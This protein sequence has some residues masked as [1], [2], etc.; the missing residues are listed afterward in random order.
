MFPECLRCDVKMPKIFYQLS[1]FFSE[2]L[3]NEFSEII[4][5]GIAQVTNI[6]F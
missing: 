4:I 6:V 3:R 1:T 5:S 2:E